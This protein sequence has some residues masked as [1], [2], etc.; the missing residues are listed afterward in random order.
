MFDLLSAA[1]R[2]LAFLVGCLPLWSLPLWFGRGL[3][4]RPPSL[5]LLRANRLLS[6]TSLPSPSPP[7]HHC[8]LLPDDGHRHPCHLGLRHCRNYWILPPSPPNRRI[9]PSQVRIG[10]CCHQIRGLGGTLSLGHGAGR[11]Q[12]LLNRRLTRWSSSSSKL[13]PLSL[14]LLF[15]LL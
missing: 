2:P 11:G 4:A 8:A 9:R 6:P 7:G 1:W 14:P 10:P 5:S 3:D 15:I 13:N 12:L